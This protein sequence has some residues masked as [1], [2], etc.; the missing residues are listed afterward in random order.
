Y[1]AMGVLALVAIVPLIA[2]LSPLTLVWLVAGGLIYTV[3]TLFYHNERIP[4]A[5]AI[6]HLFVLAGT[7]CHAIAIGTQL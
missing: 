2:R 6:W 1:I 4:Y 7:V 5:H 3:G